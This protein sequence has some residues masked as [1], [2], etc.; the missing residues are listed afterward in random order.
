MSY[1]RKQVTELAKVQEKGPETT[2]GSEYPQSGGVG[3][4]GTGQH[5]LPLGG[6]E[7]TEPEARAGPE[8]QE[9]HSL[10]AFPGTRIKGPQT[11]KESQPLELPNDSIFYFS[12]LPKPATQE[13]YHVLSVPNQ[14]LPSYVLT[15]SARPVTV[16]PLVGLQAKCTATQAPSTFRLRSH[17]NMPVPE[18]PSLSIQRWLLVLETVR[19]IVQVGAA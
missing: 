2:Q 11:P 17:Q 13:R 19:A 15:F 12:T 8:A 5:S 18:K 16:P 1:W 4:L 10:L 3:I 6:A 14:P 7:A 9:P